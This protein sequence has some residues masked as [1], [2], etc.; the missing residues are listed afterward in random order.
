MKGLVHLADLIKIM[1]RKGLST[2]APGQGTDARGD[3]HKS[4][5]LTAFFKQFGNRHLFVTGV[6]GNQAQIA[7][8]N[9]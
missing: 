3:S 7:L 6:V 4:K 5:G 2:R 1:S 9:S 8:R